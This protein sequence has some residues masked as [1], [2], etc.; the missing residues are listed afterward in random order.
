MSPRF[1]SVA[2]L[3][4]TVVLAG[5]GASV[6]PSGVETTDSAAT[7][8]PTTTATKTVAGTL[9]T[10]ATPSAASFPPGVIDDGVDDPLALTNAHAIVLTDSSFEVAMATTE[11]YENGT[12]RIRKRITGT[13][14][15]DKNR[16]VVD[17]VAPGS[18]QRMMDS[19][20]GSLSAWANGERIYQRFVIGGPASYQLLYDANGNLREPR[21]H[22]L[23]DQI[24]EDRLYVLFSAFDCS[25]ERVARDVTTYHRLTSDSI[26]NTAAIAASFD[27]DEIE[28]ANLTAVVDSR[29]VIHEYRIEYVGSVDDRTVRGVHEV[30]YDNVGSVSVERP[31]WADEAINATSG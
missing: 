2:L 1:L 6:A 4:F 17:Y 9:T 8:T 25:T 3:A 5:C 12:L 11:R 7:S 13:F 21:E 30:E 16:Y 10:T 31:S 23:A 29:G 28:H 20:T 15:Q 22:L 24:D 18:G 19:S 26:S 14:A 27:L